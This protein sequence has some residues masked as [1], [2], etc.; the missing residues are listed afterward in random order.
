MNLES[1][2]KGL[3][4]ITHILRPY[5]ANSKCIWT[6]KGRIGVEITLIDDTAHKSKWTLPPVHYDSEDAFI[7]AMWTFAEKIWEQLNE[8]NKGIQHG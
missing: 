3:S 6:D 7:S 8:N 1:Y 5:R 2:M 4:G